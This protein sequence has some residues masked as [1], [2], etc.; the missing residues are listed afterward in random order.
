MM[1][2]VDG[3]SKRDIEIA[4]KWQP[5]QQR[6]PGPGAGKDDLDLELVY[7]EVSE[8]LSPTLLSLSRCVG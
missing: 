2:L 3:H 4:Q 6:S 7:P 8:M 5:P 1:K